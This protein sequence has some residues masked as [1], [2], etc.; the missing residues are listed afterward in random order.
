MIN[1]IKNSSRGTQLLAIGAI[2][3]AVLA[4]TGLLEK[5]TTSLP[6]QLLAQVNE[7]N[8]S[9]KDYLGYLELLA[10][11]KRNP[12]REQDR[13]HVL[14]RLIEEQLLIA[15]GL[16]LGLP[17]SDPTV[18]KSIISA[19]IQSVISDSATVEPEDQTLVAFYQQNA[20][21]FAKP[22]RIQVQRMVFREKNKDQALHRAKQAHQALQ[23]EGFVEVKLRLADRDILSL[24]NT[25][26]PINKLRGYIGPSLTQQAMS[27]APNSYSPPI[28]DGSGY[29]ILWLLN[30]QNSETR[31]LNEI[32]DQVMRE[33]QRRQGDLAL[34]TYLSQLRQE[35]EV[36]IDEEFLKNLSISSDQQ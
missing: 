26:L 24:P 28:D 23:G 30:L 3:G 17:S 31:P 11:D 33:Y 20:D 16:E 2:F 32:R 19:M 21:Y 15:K 7:N 4:A 1:A 22:S 12:M 10:R 9:K 18:R 29:T 14:N 6:S 13:R 27:L 34:K 5:V 25:L 36:L 35:A 8:I